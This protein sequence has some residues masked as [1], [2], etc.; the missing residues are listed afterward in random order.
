M[1]I[2]TVNSENLAEYVASRP[3]RPDITL[4]SQVIDAVN[5][6]DPPKKDDVVKASGEESV[7]TAPDPGSQEPSAK[8]GPKPVQPRIDE[9][10]REKKEAEEFAESEYNLRLEAERR[11]SELE[12]QVKVLAP[13]VETKEPELVEPDP[14]KYTDQALFNKDWREYQDKIIKQRVSEGIAEERSRERAQQQDEL[15]RER[16]ALARKDIADF[17]EVIKSR[18]KSRGMVPS[19][20]VAA[21]MESEVGPQIAYH[22]AKNPEEEK[23]IYGLS[24]A[25]A[26]LALGKIEL[27]YTKPKENSAKP[28]EKPPEAKPVTTR[29]PA[30]ITTLKGE[31]GAIPQDL[32]GPLP[33]KEYRR[34]RNEQKARMGQR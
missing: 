12:G 13:K 25:R 2:R 26:L 8:K 18:D 32:S 5:P 30:P 34:L 27:E 1:A 10:T 3:Q 24:P 22:L 17:E 11:I 29:A 9:L 14:S 31:G 28:E 6:P 4:H 20:V 21:I 7:S 19:H 23:R 15:M 16:T 33:F